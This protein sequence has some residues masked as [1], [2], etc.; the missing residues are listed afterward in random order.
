M[1]ILETNGRYSSKKLLQSTGIY[2]RHDLR[3]VHASLFLLCTMRALMFLCLSHFNSRDEGASYSH[4]L[5]FW[6]FSSPFKAMITKVLLYNKIVS[7]RGTM[8]K[9]KKSKITFWLQLHLND[10]QAQLACW[11][12]IEEVGPSL[13]SV[14]HP[15]PSRRHRVI[16][17]GHR[18]ES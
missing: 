9:K 14:E 3:H 5:G 17:P 16:T 13:R 7:Y 10:Y 12:F 11:I 6:G 15:N 1:F 8:Q 2:L 4:L 18:S